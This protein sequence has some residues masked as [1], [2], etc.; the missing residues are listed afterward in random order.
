[1][2]TSLVSNWLEDLLSAEFQRLKI[3]GELQ[4]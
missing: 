4:M 2:K 3:T 1:M